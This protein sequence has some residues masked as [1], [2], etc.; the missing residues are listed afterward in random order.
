MRVALYA[1]V[2][3]EEQSLH[4]LSIDAQLAAL[5]DWAEDKTVV[6]E[7]VDAGISGRIPIKKR[8][9]LSR[10]LRDVEAGLIDVIAFTKL[11]RWTRNVREY[12]K[13]DEILEAHRVAWKA[14]HEDYETQTAAGRMKVGIMLVVAQDE[15]DRTS[16]RVKAVFEEK[17][18]KGLVVNGHMPL[19]LSYDNGRLVKTEDAPKVVELFN[20]YI[21]GRNINSLAR[22]S[23]E[24]LGR[25]YSPR[26]IQQMLQNEKY[27]LSG[28][29][30][31]E[32]FEAVRDII[33]QRAT[34]TVRTDRVYLFSGLLVCPECG[35]RLTVHTRVW[36]GKTY[37]YYRCDQRDRVRRCTWGASVREEVCEEWL[38]DHLVSIVRGHNMSVTKKA[39]KPVDAAALQRKLDKLTDLY[40]ED[41]LSKEEYDKRATP[42]RDA[43]KSAQMRPKEADEARIMDALDVYP[44]LS[45]N[46]QK[47]FWSFLV[48]RIVPDGDGFSVEIISL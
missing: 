10:L 33:S 20:A 6:G 23:A 38:K 25:P 31:P 45:K 4:G 28:I 44:T 34:R 36:N 42:L 46:A 43:V 40:L 24:I 18:R 32:Q 29:I 15:A 19:G 37:T 16:E 27:T 14:I 9:E 21:G 48:R 30:S 5:R 47:A 26:A 8:P 39:K 35:Y 3:T 2:S 13:A 41:K 7:Y 22:Q 1:R 17:R 12:Y 11:D